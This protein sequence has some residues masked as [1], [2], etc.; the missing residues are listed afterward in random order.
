MRRSPNR[1]TI[2]PKRDKIPQKTRSLFVHVVELSTA[3]VKVD[4]KVY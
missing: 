2:T 4:I 3:A 1:C